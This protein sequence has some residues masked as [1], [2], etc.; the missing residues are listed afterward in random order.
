MR[1]NLRVQPIKLSSVRPVLAQ[2]TT[3]ERG[4]I[5][6][7][8]RRP[9]GSHPWIKGAVLCSYYA[10]VLLAYF[11]LT[12][13]IVFGLSLI[14]GLERVIVLLLIVITYVVLGWSCYVADRN[15]E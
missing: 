3:K 1:T 5:C 7:A 2:S 11:A 15:L 14:I 8:L 13:S 4:V 10:F 9:D 12:S 6:A